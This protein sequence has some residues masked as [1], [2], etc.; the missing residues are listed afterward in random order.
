MAHLLRM[1]FVA[2]VA[3]G[4]VG[5]AAEI[6]GP[7]EGVAAATGEL[8]SCQYHCRPCPPDRIC[9]QECRPIGQCTSHCDVIALCVEGYVWDETACACV[10]DTSLEACGDVVCPAGTEC[11]NASCGICV[12][13]GGVCTQQVCDSTTTL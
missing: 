7:E 5:C 12:E 8:A 9:T 2:A 11:C 1:F 13:P 4:T 10:P 3:L 6:G